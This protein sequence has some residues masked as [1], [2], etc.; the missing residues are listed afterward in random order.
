MTTKEI[1]LK[2]IR[3]LPED[4]TVDDVVTRLE[5]MRREQFIRLVRE[6][7]AESKAGLGIPDE[8]LDAFFDGD[9]EGYT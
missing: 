5:E 9:D 1:I 2:A 8:E 6:G 3:A 4:A 7:L